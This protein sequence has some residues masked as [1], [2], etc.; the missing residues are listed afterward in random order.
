MGNIDPDTGFPVGEVKLKPRTAEKVKDK[1]KGDFSQIT[2][3]IRTRIIVETPAQ[4]RLI[5]DRIAKKNTAN[6]INYVLTNSAVRGIVS[7]L[8]YFDKDIANQ[9]NYAGRPSTRP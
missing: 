5:A 9:N 8:D 1:Y 7:Q 6:E 2:D 4:E 3:P